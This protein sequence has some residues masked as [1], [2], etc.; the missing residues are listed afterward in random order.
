MEVE[1]AAAKARAT[2]RRRA[3]AEAEAQPRRAE[4]G[5]EASG[6][7]AESDP[8][9][10]LVAR[11]HDH[12]GA[13]GQTGRRDTLTPVLKRSDADREAL[14]NAG[15][16]EPLVKLLQTGAAEEKVQAAAVL[17]SL[18]VHADNQ[19]TIAGAGAVEPLLQLLLTGNA[20]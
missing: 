11:L 2:S 14:V 1:V 13:L 4:G 5:A 10:Q 6:S 16:V 15:A 3:E 18:A 8:I 20:E 19:V 17:S 7:S 12:G 9:R